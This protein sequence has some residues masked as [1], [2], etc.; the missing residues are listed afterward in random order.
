MRAGEQ[1]SRSARAGYARRGISS[2]GHQLEGASARRG[3]GAKGHQAP[4]LELCEVPDH[5]DGLHRLAE[6]HLVGEDAADP[7]VVQTHQPVEPLQLILPQRTVLE[8]RGLHRQPLVV[9]EHAGAARLR[10]AALGQLWSEAARKLTGQTVSASAT[11]KR[12][13]LC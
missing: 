7:V 10:G 8:A 5:R 3:R 13:V 6:P 4:H 9:R 1:E 2:K 11:V 12:G